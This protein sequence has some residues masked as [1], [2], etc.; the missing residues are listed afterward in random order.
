MKTGTASQAGWV[1]QINLSQGGVPKRPVPT[2]ELKPLGLVGDSQSH[3]DIHGGP[4]RAVCLYSLERILELQSEGNPVYPGSIGENLTLA[5][6]D[7]NRIKPGTKLLLGETTRLQITKFTTPCKT[8]EASF[9]GGKI[10]RISEKTHPGWSRVYGCVLQAGLIK[11]G[12]TV[13][14]EAS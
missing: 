3:L 10:D 4:E 12:D 1:F 14:I 11:I 6:L 7:W 8:I 13:Q 2:A 9:L 5:G